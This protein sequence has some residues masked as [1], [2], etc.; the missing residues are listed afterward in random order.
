LFA[1]DYYSRPFIQKLTNSL[2][3]YGIQSGLTEDEI[4]Y[5][6]ITFVQS[7]PYTSDEVTTGFDDYPRFPYETFYD[8]GGDCEDTSILA[9]SML[10]ELGYGVV[11]L[12][13]PTH[14][15]VGIKCNPSAG[16]TYYSYENST[17]CYLETTG[18]NWDVGKMPEEHKGEKATI[19]KI[20]EKPSLEIKFHYTY[21][22]NS[23]DVYTD[24]KINVTNLGSE[25]TENTKIYAA[26]Q[27]EDETKVWD[28]ITS[29]SFNLDPEEYY[30]YKVENLHSPTGQKFRVYVRAYGDNVESKKSYGGWIYWK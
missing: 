11:M 6:I 17:F 27:T 28:S 21:T 29:E 10:Y 19:L 22:Y 8:N 4:P 30:K 1:S 23:Q 7:L 9:S 2:N 14:M 24:I 12:R 26:L 13:Y 3:E 15:A 18:E 20:A 16:Q 25:T 5:F